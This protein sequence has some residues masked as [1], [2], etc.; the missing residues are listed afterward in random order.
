MFTSHILSEQFE[1]LISNLP[2]NPTGVLDRVMPVQP[3]REFRIQQRTAVN[4][5]IG[6]QWVASELSVMVLLLLAIGHVYQLAIPVR[7]RLHPLTSPLSAPL[8][9]VHRAWDI[10]TRSKVFEALGKSSSVFGSHGSTLSQELQHAVRSIS[11][12]DDFAGLGSPS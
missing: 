3:R 10:S 12:Q 2:Q 8:V 6:R 5:L 7:L 4:I 1:T 9:V 11:D